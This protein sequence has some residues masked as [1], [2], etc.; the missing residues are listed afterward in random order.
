MI[1][2]KHPR[3]KPKKVWFVL[4]SEERIMHLAVD[5]ILAF[6][7]IAVIEALA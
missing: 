2:P 5:F 6:A 1:G 4:P 3:L 7:I